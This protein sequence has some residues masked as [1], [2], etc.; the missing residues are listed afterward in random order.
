MVAATV[1]AKPAMIATIVA[2]AAGMGQRAWP[3]GSP[4]EQSRLQHARWSPFHDACSKKCTSQTS[5]GE[6]MRGRAMVCNGAEREGVTLQFRRSSPYTTP[7]HT[8]PST[9][10]A[11]QLTNPTHRATLAAPWPTLHILH[12]PFRRRPKL[13]AERV[14]SLFL[15]REPRVVRRGARS[16][17][18][19]QHT[20]HTH[21]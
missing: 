6:G 20:Q 16:T 21:T 10:H 2:G 1:A 5:V 19:T 12:D 18:H 9:T 13:R 17:Q 7:H 14:P 3:Q 8:T 4:L 15:A 11:V